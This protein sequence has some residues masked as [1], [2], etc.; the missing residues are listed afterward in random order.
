MAHRI[1]TSGDDALTVCAPILALD[2]LRGDSRDF[3]FVPERDVCDGNGQLVA[4]VDVWAI[5]DGRLLIGEAKTTD[6]RHGD[7]GRRLDRGPACART[8]RV[9]VDG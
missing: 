5:A 6:R 8:F 7:L 1:F 4:E 3:L 9:R 2:R